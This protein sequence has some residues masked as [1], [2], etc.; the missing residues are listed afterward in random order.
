MD[1]V[2]SGLVEL[3]FGAKGVLF[4]AKDKKQAKDIYRSIIKNL[5]EMDFLYSILSEREFSVMDINGIRKPVKI[6]MEDDDE[7]ATHYHDRQRWI[8][9]DEVPVTW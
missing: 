3:D 7:V 8:R 2:S 5:K 6:Y 4:V 9:I 1:V